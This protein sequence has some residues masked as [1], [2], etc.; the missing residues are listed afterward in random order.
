V[1]GF[2]GSET[3]AESPAPAT[4][5]TDLTV[6]V[7]SHDSAA[8]LPDCLTSLRDT[9]LDPRPQVLVV[10]NAST[11]GGPDL[12][13][14][15]HPEVKL[16][17][18]D[19]N[20]GFARAVNQGWREATGRNL[21][22]LNPDIVV[23]PGALM[24]LHDYL[25]SHPDV[26]LVAP[27]LVGTDGTLQYSCR[28]HYTAGAYLLRR[29]PLGRLFPGHRALRRHLMADWDHAEV[30]E[31]D[32]VQGAAM[33]IRGEALGETALDERFF[34]YFEDVDLCLRLQR[35]GWKVVYH[36]A[37]EM[38]HHHQRASARGLWSRHKREHFK[39]WVRFSLKH[40]RGRARRS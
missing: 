35:S 27:R 7:V 28:R 31:V 15:R 10:D 25:T 5:S 18:N 9:S 30:R 17:A 3:M 20:L 29:T 6:V 8:W 4:G 26:G 32:W 36:P 13:R 21:L 38:V 37:A 12:V 33:M 23:Q 34:L 22:V 14:E 2:P 16:I 11:D 19:A 24:V 39:S 1:R 40:A